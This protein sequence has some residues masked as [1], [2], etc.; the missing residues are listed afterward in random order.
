[1]KKTKNKTSGDYLNDHARTFT[2]VGGLTPSENKKIKK[3]LGDKLAK[4]YTHVNEG[5]NDSNPMNG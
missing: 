2:A 1:M 5:W 4:K 3:F